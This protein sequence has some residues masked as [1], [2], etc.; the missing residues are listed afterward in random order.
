M[1]RLWLA[2]AIAP[3]MY[4]AAA[5]AQT[6][7]STNTTT[8]VQTS[9]TGNLTVT[10]SIVPT[11]ANTSAVTVNSSNTVT[12]SGTIGYTGGYNN[13]NAI[14][15]TGGYA[16]SIT[17]SGTIENIETSS[18]ADTNS[19]SIVDSNNGVI[20]QFAAGS[21]RTAIEL[22]GGGTFTGTITNT[23]TITVIGENSAGILIGENL[24]GDLVSSGSITDTG[25]DFYS[26][27]N[28][29]VREN[30]L[31]S[32]GIYAGP[33]TKITGNVTLSG[34]ISA[35]GHLAEGVTLQGEVT[36]A[37][38]VLGSI[39]ATG[40]RYTTQ[41]TDTNQLSILANNTP[42]SNSELMQGGPALHISGSIDSGVSIDAAVAATST[43]TATTAGTLFSYGSAPALQIDGASVIGRYGTS[44]YGLILGGTVAGSGLYN[45]NDVGQPVSSTAVYIGG[46]SS[47]TGGIQ[48]VG[49]VSASTVSTSTVG[50]LTGDAIGLHVAGTASVPKL[51]LAYSGALLASSSTTQ[52]PN[53]TG[54]VVDSGATLSQINN[55]GRISASINGITTTTNGLENSAVGGTSGVATAVTDNSGSVSFIQ[56]RGVISSLFTPGDSSATVT[57]STIALN[58][59]GGLAGHSVVVDQ[60]QISAANSASFAAEVATEAAGGVTLTAPSPSITGDILFGAANSTLEVNAGTVTGAVV[61]GTGSNQLNLGVGGGTGVV[62]NTSTAPLEVEGALV[63]NGTLS[64]DVANGTLYTTNSKGVAVGVTAANPS[65]VTPA[66]T[67]PLSCLTGGSPTTTGALIFT[68]NAHPPGGGG[69]I[70]DEFVVNG[71]ATLYTGSQIGV[72]VSDKF[73]TQATFTVIS[74]N[75]LVSGN[76]SQTLLGSIPYLYTGVINTQTGANGSVSITLTPRT[77]ANAGLNPAESAA[78]N[79]IFASFDKETATGAALLGKITKGDFVHLYDQFMPDYAGGPFETMAL[80]QQAIER[81]EADGPIKLRDDEG[82]GWVQEISYINNRDSSASVNGYNGSGFGM[83]GGYE[84]ANGDGAVGVAVAFMTNAIHD[85]VQA[86]ESTLTASVVEAGVYWRSSG[87]GL[88]AN[89][90]LNAGWAFL[91]SDRMVIDQVDDN[92]AATLLRSAK[93]AWNGGL[94]SAQIGLNYPITVGRFYLKPEFSADY[95]ALYESAHAEHDGGQAVDLALGSKTSQEGSVQGDLVMGATFGD[96]V[97]WRPELTLGWREILFG[98]PAD[99][100]AHFASGGSNFT[101]SPQFDE[102]GGLLARLGLHAGGAYADFTADAGGV[103]RSGYESYDARA[104]A[105]FLF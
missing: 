75:N 31:V 37:V 6:T 99:T 21:N 101:L 55:D 24:T 47:I 56:N 2:V 100:V 74:A 71:T 51:D 69:P 29:T 66:S 38:E 48:L 82:R 11:T 34:T 97:K 61:F 87:Y 67:T 45:L 20:G 22:T 27:T 7:V 14:L 10:G 78:F 90:N 64:V 62:T 3:L 36:G 17:N 4:A 86:P 30:G 63:N 19:D 70:N 50:G 65:G 94:V 59:Q 54:I 49:E 26:L 16:G 35:T 60:E 9:T 93:S 68:A 83:I 42:T 105:R 18:Y 85:T 89:A 72:L 12:N 84:Q 57:G 5:N 91:Q 52:S 44:G 40:Y 46:S 81:A 23:G 32:Y 58:L 79:A 96:A 41:P 102:K 73:T 53:V 104:V 13:T 15:V 92:T 80:G 33:T 98:G 8:P 88:N 1:K 43:T 28:P 95:M 103:F 76:I 25:G 39:S 77:P